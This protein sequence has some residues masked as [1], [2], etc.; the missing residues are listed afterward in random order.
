M[1]ALETHAFGSWN[2]FKTDWASVLKQ[3]RS[4]ELSDRDIANSFVFRCMGCSTHNLISSFD[5][6]L[7]DQ[8]PGS[9]E[10]PLALYPGAI[11]SY[12]SSWRKINK[13][14]D[15][16]EFSPDLPEPFHDERFRRA[17]AHAQHHGMPTR[18][19]DWSRSPYIA[20]FFAA[21][22][23]GLCRSGYTSVWC[24]DTLEVKRAFRKEIYI[25]SSDY[26][27]NKRLINQRGCFTRNESNLPEMDYLFMENK[28][29]FFHRPNFPILFR[30]DIP[31]KEANLALEDLNYMG[32]DFLS[33]YP[34]MEGVKA[35][36]KF[37]L[38]EAASDAQRH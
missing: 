13:L 12:V 32:I 1:P 30:F 20:A 35:F 37:K 36:A 15:S 26:Y 21:T 7:R 23:F 4:H 27:D 34:D 3:L 18:L 14:D 25:I 24:L 28:N 11:R 16:Y 31:S 17:E 5:R 19:L 33:V 38:L 8:V 9:I 6:L 22:N 29:R 10:D 2:E